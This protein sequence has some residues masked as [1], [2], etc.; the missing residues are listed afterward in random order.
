MIQT[1]AI[2]IAVVHAVSTAEAELSGQVVVIRS[3]FQNE[4]L[5]G[6]SIESS[7]RWVQCCHVVTVS[8]PE[9]NNSNDS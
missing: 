3:H 9:I 4:E 5:V 6:P 1:W 7:V 2:H 8:P